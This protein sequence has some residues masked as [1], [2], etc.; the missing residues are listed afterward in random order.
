LNVS[1]AIREAT[2]RLAKTS[3]TARLD[4][5]LLMA[6]ALRVSRSDLLLKHMN[7]AVPEG[8]AALLNRREA[9]EPI[10]YITGTQEFYGR[11]FMVTCEVLIPRSD[12]ETVVAVA[13]AA[14]SSPGRV[15]DCGVGS[16]AL[17]LSVLA[18]RPQAEGIGI[19]R[20]LG[21]MA[22]ASQNA[23]RLG[24]ADRSRILHRDW[25]ESDWKED[26]GQFDL[27]LANPPYVENGA[28]LEASVRDF[29]PAGALFAGPDGLDDYR[30]LIPQLADLLTENGISVLEIGVAQ[31]NAVS[32]I[33]EKAGFSVTCHKDLGGR[34]RALVLT[35]G[36]GK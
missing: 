23:A 34:P 28:P 7:D 4:A 10:A 8:F 33:A 20:S 36:L 19:D 29:E 9:C 2:E 13:L 32:S 14:A 3:D 35:L 24:V 31:E 25:H 15:L 18:E 22:I 30:I 5:E 12:S 6:H 1:Q 16:G 26:L 11:S 27:I 17:L 21:A